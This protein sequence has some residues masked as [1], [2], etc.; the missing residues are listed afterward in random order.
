MFI[1]DVLNT[2]KKRSKKSRREFLLSGGFKG[3]S[4]MGKIVEASVYGHGCLMNEAI[5]FVLFT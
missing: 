5:R 3:F 4:N 2:L 1:Y